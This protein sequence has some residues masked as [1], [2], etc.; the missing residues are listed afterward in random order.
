MNVKQRYTAEKMS[1]VL[2]NLCQ[3]EGRELTKQDCKTMK[4][5]QQQWDVVKHEL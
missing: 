1:I 5:L 4:E 2:Y 3:M